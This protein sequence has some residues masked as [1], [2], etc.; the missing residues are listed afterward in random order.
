MEA[1][2]HGAAVVVCPTQYRERRY[3]ELS[4]PRSASLNIRKR[5]NDFPLGEGLSLSKHNFYRGHCDGLTYSRNNS[6]RQ[7]RHE[8]MLSSARISAPQ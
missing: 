3:D 2:K 1:Q 6:E 8:P 5:V 7:R 4:F